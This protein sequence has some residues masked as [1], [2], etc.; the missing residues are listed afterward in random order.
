MI[1][2]KD[3]KPR[4]ECPDKTNIYFTK[5]GYGNGVSPC[6]LGKPISKTWAG[7]ILPN[8]VGMVFACNQEECGGEPQKV[9]R[10][11]DNIEYPQNA[12]NWYAGTYDGCERSATPKLGA[13]ACWR[14]VVRGKVTLGH[15]AKVV[16]TD[17]TNAGTVVAESGYG[18]YKW[19]LHKYG[20]YMYKGLYWQFQGYI[21]PSW[22]DYT[23][24]DNSIPV[25]TKVKIVAKGNAR[26][27][28]KGTK[29]GGI[30]WT[31]YVLAYDKEKAY[32][33]KV[34]N[35]KGVVT[36]YYKREALEVK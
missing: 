3:Y 32:P 20:K 11:Y 26:A 6:I 22:I 25:G 36:G 29:S 21:I 33:Y 35:A 8:C 27:D 15:V 7:S 13:I 31:R 18:S 30:G 34:G 14:K 24:E 10:L 4:T 5:K 23:E 12:Q 9:G 28:G 1:K 16:A 2:L 17:G 19:R